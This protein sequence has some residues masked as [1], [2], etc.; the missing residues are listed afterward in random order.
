MLEQ[1]VAHSRHL[2]GSAATLPVDLLN[3]DGEPADASGTLTVQV[4]KA[5]GTEVLAAGS[6]TSNPTGSGSYTAALTA[7]QTAT[8]E[9]LTAVWTDAGDSSTWTTL[10]EIV[11]GYYFTLAEARE[12]DRSLQAQNDDT[13]IQRARRITE[14]EFERICGV[15]FV[16]RYRRVRLDGYGRSSLLLP[17]PMVRTVRSVRVYSSATS[18]TAFTADEL[19]AL[20]ANNAGVITRGDGGVFAA[21][22]KNIV[23]EYEH[24]HDRPPAEV[25]RA[26]IARARQWIAFG[27]SGIPDRTQTYVATEVGTFGL[28]QAGRAKTG[29]DWIDAALARWSIMSP[30]IA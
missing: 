26:S 2:R 9:M 12:H 18:Y 14:D 21:G 19:A 5:D 27:N 17:D 8:L 20:S 11:G 29:T 30:G 4:T 24:G 15:A 23:V 22:S 3:Q 1:P 16:P 28:A 6:S 7:A 13:L 25:Q 10:H